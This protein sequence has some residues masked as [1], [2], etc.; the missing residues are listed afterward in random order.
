[1][2]V[3]VND[4]FHPYPNFLQPNLVSTN[5]P[6]ARTTVKSAVSTSSRPTVTTFSQGSNFEFIDYNTLDASR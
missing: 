4:F 2:L 5:I 3:I 6:S 1:M